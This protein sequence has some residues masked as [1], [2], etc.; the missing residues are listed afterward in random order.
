MTLGWDTSRLSLCVDPPN[1]GRGDDPSPDQGLQASE[2]LVSAN[3]W[4]AILAQV[5][6]TSCLCSALIP[7]QCVV[8]TMTLP[9]ALVQGSD[10]VLVWVV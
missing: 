4:K 7:N 5:T 9:I 3:L 6:E 1:S 10:R 8:M 2:T